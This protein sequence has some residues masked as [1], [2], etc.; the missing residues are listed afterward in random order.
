MNLHNIQITAIL[1]Q[2]FA[3]IIKTSKILFVMFRTIHSSL[4]EILF[5]NK[6]IPSITKF[7][8]FMNESNTNN[9]NI[10]QI[11]QG[12][13]VY[14][15]Q[16]FPSIEYLNNSGHTC[17]E[18]LSQIPFLVIGKENENVISEDLGCNK[19]DFMVIIGLDY[20]KNKDVW[21]KVSIVQDPGNLLCSFDVSRDLEEYKEIPIKIMMFHAYYDK[22][23]L[24]LNQE[25]YYRQLESEYK[26]MKFFSSLEN[27]RFG[28]N[29]D[30][31]F[32]LSEKIVDLIKK[33]MRSELIFNEQFLLK[34]LSIFLKNKFQ[35][36]CN[37]RKRK[38]G[39]GYYVGTK[40]E[41]V[42]TTPIRIKKK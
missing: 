35:S 19:F 24:E 27:F 26:N 20:T 17:N 8:S 2:I 21:N 1:L 30:D 29:N 41:I 40:E 14:G 22:I 42:K 12:Y 7:F 11:F 23:D 38:F 33:E 3:G 25:K 18:I 36:M 39:F 32:I 5:L 10:F 31:P 34:D 15:Y 4:K 28:D 6:P 16:N 37:N 9:Y 13:K